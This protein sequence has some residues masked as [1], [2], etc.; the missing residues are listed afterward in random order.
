MS[1]VVNEALARNFEKV[2]DLLTTEEVARI[3]RVTPVTV[4][5]WVAQQDLKCVQVG[6]KLHRF[7]KWCIEEYISTTARSSLH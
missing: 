3:F 1:Q 4:L 2:P 7:P 5:R 6:P